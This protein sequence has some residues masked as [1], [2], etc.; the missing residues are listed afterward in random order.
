MF[1][2]RP[3]IHPSPQQPVNFTQKSHTL[4]L[5][6][7]FIASICA[8]PD[9][10]QPGYCFHPSSRVNSGAATSFF[11]DSCWWLIRAEAMSHLLAKGVTCKPHESTSPAPSIKR[12]IKQATGNRQQHSL[13]SSFLPLYHSKVS[14]IIKSL[15]IQ[16]ITSPRR[17]S[18]WF[19]VLP[20]RA[21][22]GPSSYQQEVAIELRMSFISHI[23]RISHQPSAIK[24]ARLQY[25]RSHSI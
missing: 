4:S 25:Y 14:Q 21:F 22:A 5:Y 24:S 20:P 9:G 15:S 18:R 7:L 10:Q 1:I 17:C 3:S 11:R 13:I 6:S 8:A 19:S 16:Y 12:N 23:Y 2:H